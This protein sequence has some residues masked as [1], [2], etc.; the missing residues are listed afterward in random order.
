LPRQVELRIVD[1]SPSAPASLDIYIVAP[2]VDIAQLQ[3]TISPLE[4][5]QAS[6]YVDLMTESSGYAQIMV[7]VTKSGDTTRTQLLNKI[8]T[9][10]DGQIRTLV[11]VDSPGG[12]ALS[13][14]PL[15]LNDLN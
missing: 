9:L 15:E 10:Y 11:L 12:G 4:L 1:A 13:F 7:I 6:V 3:P 14:V 2:G 8:Y 5:G